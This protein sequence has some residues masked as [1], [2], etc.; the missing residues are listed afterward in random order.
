MRME[1]TAQMTAIR[2][3]DAMRSSPGA[4]LKTIVNAHPKRFPGTTADDEAAA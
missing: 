2:A 4:K 1:R 3:G